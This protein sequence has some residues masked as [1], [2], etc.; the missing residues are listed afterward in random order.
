MSSSN[1]DYQ[2]KKSPSRVVAAVCI[3]LACVGLVVGMF[4]IFLSDKDAAARD[5]IEYWAAGQLLVHGANPYDPVDLLRLER[6]VGLDGTKPK[7]S[8]SPPPVLFLTLPLGFMTPKLGLIS[9]L[10]VLNGCLLA[11]M[12]I[13]W[14]LHGRPA[15]GLQFA[16]YLFAPVVAC[17]MAG[18]LGLFL[19]LGIVLFLHLYERKPFLAGMALLP[20]AFKPHLF[21]PFSIVLLLWV[22]NKKADRVLLGF[23]ASLLASCVPVIWLD[24]LV[25]TQYSAMMNSTGVLHA[26]VPTLS[27][28]FRFLI[29]RDAVWLQFIPEIGACAW[30][31]W[32][33][34]TRR[35]RWD[36]M[37]DGLLVLLVSAVCT[38]YAWFSDEALLLAP[39]LSGVF[40]AAESMRA[41]VVIGVIAGIA[42]VEISTVGQM[43]SAYYLWTTPAWLAWYIYATP[44]ENDQ[45]QGLFESMSSRQPS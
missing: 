16:A 2:G 24:R 41:L 37:N 11:S 21:L 3:V 23:A 32:Y 1:S 19:L 14:D 4:V 38:P 9:W 40:R 35:D 25:W 39:V 28:T 20:C 12:W 27:V 42:L 29:D 13:L 45:S 7:V 43:A 5:F 44:R 18:Q 33:F 36:W 31:V 15:S 26:F 8:F 10:L 17:F 22:V 34:C 6:G 30:S